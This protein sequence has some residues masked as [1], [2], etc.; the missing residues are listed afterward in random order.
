MT[1]SEIVAE[2]SRGLCTAHKIVT[3]GCAT[4]A[5]TLRAIEAVRERFRLH[6]LRT[7]SDC[8]YRMANGSHGHCVHGTLSESRYVNVFEPPPCW[9][10]LR[11]MP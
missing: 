3:E 4:C 1:E 9:C 8:A 10:P 5:P 2:M 6:V 11:D 7:C